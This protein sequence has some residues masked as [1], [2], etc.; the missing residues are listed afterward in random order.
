MTMRESA[1]VVR[2]GETSDVMTHDIR[3]DSSPMTAQI[4][5]KH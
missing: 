3:N 5:C 4:T 2:E 1:F